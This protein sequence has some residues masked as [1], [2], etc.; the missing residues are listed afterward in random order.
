MPPYRSSQRNPSPTALTMDWRTLPA[1]PHLGRE[2]WACM[3]PPLGD[4]DSSFDDIQVDT[5]PPFSY[6]PLDSRHCEIRILHLYG[7]SGPNSDGSVP[8]ALLRHESLDTK[9][10]YIALSYVWGESDPTS[11]SVGCETM[12]RDVMV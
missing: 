7:T 4:D 2:D 11:V 12:K 6:G 5:L 8:T 3:L 10:P 9:P 1:P